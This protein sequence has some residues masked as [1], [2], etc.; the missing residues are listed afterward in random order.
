ML[1]QIE[2]PG[3]LMPVCLSALSYL[4]SLPL[5][6]GET[7]VLSFMCFFKLDCDPT[8]STLFLIIGVYRRI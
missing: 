1:T 4:R 8:D 3:G 2:F 5:Q 6:D 7:D